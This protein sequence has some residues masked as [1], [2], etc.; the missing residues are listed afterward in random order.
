MGFMHTNTCDLQRGIAKDK[1]G[2]QA[3]LL[4]ANDA[5]VTRLLERVVLF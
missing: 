4:W 2:K 3:R 5:L 1:A